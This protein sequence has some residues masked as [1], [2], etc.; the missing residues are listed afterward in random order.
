MK[1]NLNKHTKRPPCDRHRYVVTQG[2]TLPLLGCLSFYESKLRITFS[3]LTEM[4][5]T[6][7]YVSA[8]SAMFPLKQ[9]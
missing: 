9:F 8:A 6:L 5:N 7:I 3:V 2:D 4:P 1:Q